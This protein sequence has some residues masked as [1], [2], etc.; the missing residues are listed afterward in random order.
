[1]KYCPY[2]GASIADSAAS[3]CVECGKAFPPQ[4]ATRENHSTPPRKPES[5]RPPPSTR[6]KLQ[7]PWRKPNRS[8]KRTP[9]PI[10]NPKP[11]PQDEGYD[12]Y[13][14]DV[15]PA[16]DGHVRERMGP[17]LIKRAVMVAAGALGLIILAV[18]AMYVL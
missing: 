2:C 3:F 8:T 6:R 18:V 4:K 9:A 1:M 10:R 7:K 11:N 15:Q 13:Y 5:R 14:D 16:D 17:E 12:G